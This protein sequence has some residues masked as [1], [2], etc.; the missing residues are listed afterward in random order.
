M[1]DKNNTGLNNSAF[2]RGS[3]KDSNANNTNRPLHSGWIEGEGRVIMAKGPA[4]I[5][6]HDRRTQ[7]WVGCRVASLC[8]FFG[9][10]HSPNSD[11]N[12]WSLRYTRLPNDDCP[13]SIAPQRC[14]IAWY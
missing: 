8:W 1:Q 3:F 14:M 9:L 2:G 6:F 5:A 10:K 4:L 12:N 7:R 13:L 11:D